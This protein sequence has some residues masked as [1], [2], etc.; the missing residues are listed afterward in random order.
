MEINF[1]VAVFIHLD[2][3]PISYSQMNHSSATNPAIFI[4]VVITSCADNCTVILLQDNVSVN[5]SVFGVE[6]E[7]EDVH[8]SNTT[9]ELP[10]ACAEVVPNICD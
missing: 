2:P 3:H 4:A 7:G 5:G 10:V 1:L 9:C 8:S 6:V